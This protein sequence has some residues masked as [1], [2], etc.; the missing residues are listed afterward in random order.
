MINIQPTLIRVSDHDNDNINTPYHHYAFPLVKIKEFLNSKYGG[1]FE[2]YNTHDR[3]VISDFRAVLEEMVNNKPEDV[4]ILANVYESFGPSDVTYKEEGK[5]SIKSALVNNLF[6]FHIHEVALV[7]LPIYTYNHYYMENYMFARNDKKVL[8]FMHYMDQLER[9]YMLQDITIF[10]DTDEGVKQT[11]EKITHQI[12]REDVLLDPR[13]KTEIFRS[14]DEFF[15]HSGSFFKKYDIPYKRGIL[16][17]GS[18]GNGKT[19]LVKSIAGSVSAPIVYWQINEF[20]HS[21]SIQEIFT[22]VTK[23][24]PM[25]L[26]IEDIDS[27]P[28]HS[29]S[30]FLNT[31]DGATSKEGIFL[32]GTTNY[33]ERIDP[34]LINRAGR[35]DRAYEIKQP[36]DQLRKDY[37]LRKGVLQFIEE[38]RFDDLITQTKGLSVA[39]LNEVYM[40]IALERHYEQQVDFEKIIDDLLS[41][42]KKASKQN[43]ISDDQND[44][45]GF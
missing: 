6:Y 15:L 13:L 42:Q 18:P 7:T 34:A 24:A 19:T 5:Y 37:L 32:I 12:T 44:R 28:A 36:D 3:R 16:L 35:F 33:P 26:V 20:T 23:L 17:Y 43:W 41:N 2:I 40:S 31:L 8:D 4:E 11:K 9:D 22:K 29:R 21:Y 10:T 25:I 27:M 14:I 45:V 30:V 38:S 39:Q 1:G